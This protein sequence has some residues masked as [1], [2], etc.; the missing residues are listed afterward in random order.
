M[1]QNVAKKERG[2]VELTLTKRQE[3]DMLLM[4]AGLELETIRNVL[5]RDQLSHYAAH[6]DKP[7]MRIRAARKLAG[8]PYDEIH[9]TEGDHYD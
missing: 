2:Q 9:M 8:R 5:I 6:L 7:R 1:A 4:N 3:I